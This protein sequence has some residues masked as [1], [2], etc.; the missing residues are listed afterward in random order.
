MI[1]NE[2]TFLSSDKKTNI[3][4]ITCLPKDGKYTR[5]FQ[6]LHGMYEYIERYLPFFEFLTTKGFVVVGHDH[7]GHGQSINSKEDLGYFGE[8]NPN[9]LLIQD[10]HTLRLITQKKYPNLPYFMAG[11]SI[12]SYLLRQYVCLYNDD[13][14][15]IILLGSGFLS[16]CITSMGIV[17]CKVMSCFKGTHHRSKLAKKLSMGGG[18]Y[19]KYDM[20]KKDLNN[21]WI[22][23]DPNVVKI[24][25]EDEKVNFEFTLNGFLCSTQ[26]IHYSCNPSNVSKI[27]KDLP[28]LFVSGDCDPVG[29]NGEGVKKAYEMMKMV[30]SIDVTM[31]LYKNYRHEV[32]NELNKEDV[33]EY[34]LAW[35][36]E[37]T[38]LYKNNN[39]IE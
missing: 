26:T 2:F 9:D 15:G 21:S 34:I 31:K 25:N 23:R 29:D 4:A 20:E 19:K 16:S 27:K 13:L 18:A 35:L 39:N 6:M 14:A 33:Y 8:P 36:E 10:I 1:K 5:V 7:L 12:G 32:L 17:F 22:S 38:L 30:G 24:Y 11:H 3:H 37:K 28:I